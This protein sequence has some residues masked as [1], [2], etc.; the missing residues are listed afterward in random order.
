MIWLLFSSNYLNFFI[1]FLI[2]LLLCSYILN[3]NFFT[4]HLLTFF[5]AFNFILLFLFFFELTLVLFFII[6]YSWLQF[7]FIYIHF[8]INNILL[9]MLCLISYLDFIRFC[10]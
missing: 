7:S 1:L 2:N 10:K 4:L 3:D 5:A 8:N 6:L 9:L